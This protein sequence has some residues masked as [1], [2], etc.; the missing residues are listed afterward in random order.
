MHLPVK[1]ECSLIKTSSPDPSKYFLGELANSYPLIMPYLQRP[2]SKEPQ[3]LNKHS[4]I[5][6]PILLQGKVDGRYHHYVYR[7]GN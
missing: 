3:V 6:S 1:N 7:H 4:L 5:H 2:F